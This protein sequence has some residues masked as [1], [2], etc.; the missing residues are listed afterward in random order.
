MR[1][2]EK[3][4][5]ERG[6]L[7]PI[8]AA[9]LFC[10][11]S[12]RLVFAASPFTMPRLSWAISDNGHRS[13]LR[14]GWAR[15][16]W[17]PTW[18]ALITFRGA[19]TGGCD[20]WHFYRGLAEFGASTSMSAADFLSAILDQTTSI[21]WMPIMAQKPIEI[22][23]H[24]TR[25]KWMPVFSFPTLSQRIPIIDFYGSTIAIHFLQ[26]ICNHKMESCHHFSR[27]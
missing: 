13:S 6:L 10:L 24:A 4:A 19:D 8:S 17:F 22:S 25:I 16:A 2:R 23:S 1:R 18:L 27:R 26:T 11:S 9:V 21:Q 12:E 14:F 3:R 5:N 15:F 20:P 7:A